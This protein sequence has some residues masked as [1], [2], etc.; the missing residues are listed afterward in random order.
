MPLEKSANGFV[1]WPR[2]SYIVG[3]NDELHTV[4][5]NC[6]TSVIFS[7]PLEVPTGIG[8]GVTSFFMEGCF[9]VF[10]A[11]AF[12]GTLA[13]VCVFCL[14]GEQGALALARTGFIANFVSTSSSLSTK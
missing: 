10:C 1:E 11:A 3:T 2:L 9:V 5:I 12:C 6:G 14:I 8:S 4:S 7:L 13:V